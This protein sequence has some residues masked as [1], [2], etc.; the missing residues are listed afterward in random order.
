MEFME[1]KSQKKIVD[2]LQRFTEKQPN[3][4]TVQKREY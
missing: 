2:K 3:A 4:R 1:D